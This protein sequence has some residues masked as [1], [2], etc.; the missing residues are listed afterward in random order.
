[1]LSPSLV[2]L[3]SQRPLLLSSIVLPAPLTILV[4]APHPD[5]FDA[6][7]VSL[8]YLTAQGHQLHLA[9]MTSGANGVEDG[10]QGAKTPDD[11]TAIRQSEQRAS[12]HFFGLPPE[13]LDFLRLWEGV[14]NQ[15]HDARDYQKLRAYLHAKRPDLVFLPHG[16]DSNQTHRRTYEAFHSIVTKDGMRVL[17]CLNLDAKT[18]AMRRD[19]YMYFGDEEA[20]WKGEL[21]RFHRSQHERNLKTR[22]YGFDERVLR[23][24][25]TSAV[26]AGSPTRYA[27]VFELQSFGS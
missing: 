3:P 27:E 4:L 13:R 5:D 25:R 6:I 18:I 9:V 20:A 19:V 26:Q 21:L 11:K 12:C 7:G 15:S 24:N 10:W 16:N 17:A 2:P 23:I 1:M 8:R 22:G 14:G